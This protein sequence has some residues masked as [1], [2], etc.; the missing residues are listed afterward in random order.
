MLKPQLAYSLFFFLFLISAVMCAN[1]VKTKTT[2]TTTTT[3]KQLDG[4]KN[5]NQ[6]NSTT[7]TRITS[8]STTSMIIGKT[9]YSVYK[10]L[11]GHANWIW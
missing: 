10:T 7:T 11:T 1:N 8:T 9:N 4:I 2:T 3:R 6:A 5:Q